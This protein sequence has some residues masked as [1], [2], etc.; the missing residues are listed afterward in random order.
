MEE[1]RLALHRSLTFGNVCIMLSKRLQEGKFQTC[2]LQQGADLN[3]AR[4]WTSL[5]LNTG[6]TWAKPP[7]RKSSSIVIDLD[8]TFLFVKKGQSHSEIDVNYYE[9]WRNI[10]FQKSGTSPSQ[11][12]SQSSNWLLKFWRH[13]FARLRIGW[14]S[15]PPISET[16]R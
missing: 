1:F 15:K 12:Q 10:F 13:A 3:E 9:L 2:G 11:S 14:L 7:I 6:W 16:R 5:D 8:V 4:I